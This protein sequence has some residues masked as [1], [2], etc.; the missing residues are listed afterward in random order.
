LESIPEDITEDNNEA[1]A[2]VFIEIPEGIDLVLEKT[3]LSPNPLVND[4]VIFTLKISNASIDELPVTNIEVEDFISDDSGFVYLD[5]NTLTGE[6]DRSTGIWSI[7]SLNRG[8]EVTLEIRVRVPSEGRFSN[9]AQIRRSSPADGNLEN[10]ES[11]VEVNVSLPSPADVGFLFNQFSPNGDGTNDVLKINKVNRESN[12][13]ES[14]IYNIQI[15]NRYG[16]LVFEG[17]N[18]TDSEVWD[19]TWKGKDAPDGT[20]FYT[21]S[22]DIGNGPEPKKGWIQLIR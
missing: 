7:E 20:Y 5:H 15:F 6:Y 10:N 17:N 11:T 19:G 14:I 16:N 12:F 3:A 18:K 21:M 1:T 22:I 2:E 9:T 4:E 13:E 8:Q